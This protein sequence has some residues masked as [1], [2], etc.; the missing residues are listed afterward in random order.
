MDLKT[1]YLS[2]DGRASRSDY[3][4][5]FY[6]PMIVVAFVLGI[7]EEIIMPGMPILSSLFA[8]VTLWPSI[9]VT[10]KRLH[11]RNRS[12]WFMLIGLIPIVGWVYILVDAGILRGTVGENRFGPD[13]LG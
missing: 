7:I 12:G 3:W 1:L 13:P 11:D 9:A 10:A 2:I 6:L 8:L 5:R 4:L